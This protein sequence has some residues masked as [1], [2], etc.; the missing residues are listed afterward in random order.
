MSKNYTL[1]VKAREDGEL[2]LEFPDDLMDQVGWHVGDQ[3]KW[4]DRNDG[5]FEL[6][7]V[8]T[9]WVL[10]E[11]VST[12]RHRYMVQAPV[13][14]SEWALDTVSME[15]AIEFSQK[16]LGEQIASHRV[17][18]REEALSLCRTDNDYAKSWTDDKLVE[19]FFTPVVD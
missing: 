8:P 11:C 10:V 6:T 4:A 12:F 19:V 14:K 1:E 15:E 9:D 5:S 7:K 17:V 16:H 2:Y 18:S 13:G 3:L